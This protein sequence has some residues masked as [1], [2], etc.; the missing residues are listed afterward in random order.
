MG[1]AAGVVTRELGG[2]DGARSDGGRARESLGCSGARRGDLDR[3]RDGEREGGGRRKAGQRWWQSTVHKMNVFSVHYLPIVVL[4]S[5]PRRGRRVLRMS[6]HQQTLTLTSSVA[7]SRQRLG[8]HSVSF[9]L[10]R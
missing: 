4:A 6:R 5:R 10:I 1:T 9:T 7:V 3:W 8:S 2:G